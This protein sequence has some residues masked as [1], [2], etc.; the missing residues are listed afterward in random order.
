MFQDVPCLRG[1][2]GFGLV[3]T[4]W[5]YAHFRMCTYIVCSMLLDQWKRDVQAFPFLTTSLHGVR[6]QDTRKVI[7]DKSSCNSVTQLVDHGT[8]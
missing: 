2:G 1:L 3:P 6:T 7:F 8:C 4:I 5:Y